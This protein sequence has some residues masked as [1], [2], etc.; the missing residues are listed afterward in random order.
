MTDTIELAHEPGFSLGRVTVRP[1]QRELVHD[2][3]RREVLEHRVMQVLIALSKADGAIL[4]RDE[5]LAR[6]WSGR[7]VGDDAI[8]RVM[9][10]L[11]RTAQGIGS[12]S[13]TVE[14]ITKVGY[15]LVEQDASVAPA[16]VAKA[17]SASTFSRR[18][19]LVM[20]VTAGVAG[21]AGISALVVRRLRSP[22]TAETKALMAQAWTAWTQGTADGNSQAIGL[23]RRL[24]ERAPQTADAWGLLGCAYADLAQ[25]WTH[26][27]ERD[28]VRQ[29]ARSAG[30]HALELDP[31]NACGRV[32][33]AY[34]RPLR[35]N[36]LL[37]EREFR[38]AMA[39][40][41]SKTLGTFSVAYLLA[42]VGRFSDSA[43]LFQRVG[44]VAPTVNQ[45]RHQVAAL[46]GAGR[47]E[48]A[49]RL[50]EEAMSIYAANPSIWLTRFGLLLFGGRARAAIA[51]LEETEARPRDMPQE[52]ID[53]LMRLAV[54]VETRAPREVSALVDHETRKGRMSASQ[55][56]NAI[57]NLSAVGHADESFAFADAYFFSRGFVISDGPQGAGERATATLEEREP[58]FLF[59]PST[60]AM[61]SDPRFHG[62]TAELGLAQYWTDA[63]AQPDYKR[64]AN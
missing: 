62:L 54:A 36:W 8:N 63:K 4:T 60:R 19:A 39:S 20:G 25:T 28:A 64:L 6:C 27:S 57:Q 42:R 34:A 38:Q 58:S 55:A 11:R 40:Q 14:T 52:Q 56:R 12:N 23:Y 50:L 32:A 41:P 49:E 43:P 47:L 2:D 44:N 16:S 21:V 48:E 17:A 7:V 3:G 15:R 29:R 30:R 59:H 9:S 24:L 45:Y 46:W 51:M 53:D 61:R 5:L 18:A 35:G 26:P 1:A 37:M 13:F 10:R 22:E 31:Q 33:I